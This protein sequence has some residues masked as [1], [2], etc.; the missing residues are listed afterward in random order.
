MLT[1]IIA[2]LVTWY[3]TKVYYTKSTVIK[4]SKFDAEELLK[5]KCS[6]CSRIV[7]IHK[8]NL[9]VPFYCSSCK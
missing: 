6:K 1:T 5:A 9:R 2:M 7:S 4:A 3:A 8:D